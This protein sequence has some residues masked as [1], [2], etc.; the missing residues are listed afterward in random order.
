M[1]SWTLDD[2]RRL[3]QK[4]ANEGVS[5]HQRPFRAAME[6]LG[7]SFTLGVNGNPEVK[8]ILDAYA[9]MIPEVNTNWPGTGS[10]FIASF[11][12]VRKV[13]LP[14]VFG[15]VSLQSWKIAGFAS[16]KEWWTW[17][18]QD[19]AIAKDAE[20]SIADI[21]DFSW[22]LNEIQHVK[23]E[24]TTLWHMAQ[25]NIE[26][27]ANTLPTAFSHD[28]VIQLICM[29][30]ELSMK[31]SL[32]YKGAN[33]NSF[34]KKVGHDLSLLACQM[35]EKLPHRDDLQIQTIVKA[36]P[37]Y[38]KSRYEPIGLKRLQVIKLALDVQFIAAS[39]LRRLTSADHTFQME[40]EP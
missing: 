1:S 36:L 9:T 21:C 35:S 10:G 20:S 22:G 11:D 6:I 31:A 17:C 39:S 18:S 19:P 8:R 26:N 4:Y 5:F 2:L 23:K 33:P 34:G 15:D 29:V 32:V 37:P 7:N 27:I 40:N 28:A 14:V 38:V 3:N 13:K 12:R 30:A 16:A 25:S 24:A